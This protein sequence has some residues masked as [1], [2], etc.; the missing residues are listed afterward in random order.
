MTDWLASAGWPWVFA[1]IGIGVVNILFLKVTLDRVALRAGD[2]SW[3][4]LGLGMVVRLA[5]VV[6]VL[7]LAVQQSLIAALFAFMGFWLVRW[8]LLF[9]L[10]NRSEPK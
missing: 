2:N 10:N 9:W 1:G 4:W 3:L 6:G 8:P 5:L 7:L